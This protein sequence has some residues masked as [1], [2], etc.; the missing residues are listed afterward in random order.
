MCA[1]EPD[2]SGFARLCAALVD[3]GVLT[4]S[5][6]AGEQ[7][8]WLVPGGFRRLFLDDPG[9]WRLFANQQ[10]GFRARCPGCGANLVPV[11]S[12]AWSSLRGPRP[13]PIACPTCG[14]AHDLDAVDFAPTAAWGR[15]AARIVEVQSATP[16]ADGIALIA[17][18]L[19]PV[20]L[21]AARVG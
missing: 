14:G 3:R 6:L 7:A 4:E 5:G 13:A 21:V 1:S 12:A 18:Y 17:T 19:G 20:R 10:G 11:L 9:E 2:P 15:W 8:P 16:T